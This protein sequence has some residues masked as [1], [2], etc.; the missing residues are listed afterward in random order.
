MKKVF[1]LFLFVI[2]N[3]CLSAQNNVLNFRHRS[4]S[5]KEE[6]NTPVRNVSTNQNYIDIEYD[7]E[8]AIAID[9]RRNDETFQFIKIKGFGF[10]DNIGK[11][12][13]PVYNDILAVP[14]KNGLS[15]HIIESQYTDFEGFYIHPALEPE[16]GLV[17]DTTKQRFTLDKTTYS[18]DFYFP[19]NLVEIVSIQDY[20]EVPLAFVQIRPIQYNPKTRQLRCYSKI[21]YRI[22]FTNNERLKLNDIKQE[23]L[24]II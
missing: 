3:I 4:V 14:S 20:R 24:D 1:I 18:T 15:I 5:V 11:P 16:T 21:K 22:I 10:M 2:S 13:L 7:F 12:A 17:G 6:I 19:D 9:I 23:A 8:E